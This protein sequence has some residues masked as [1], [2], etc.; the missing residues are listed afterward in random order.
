MKK[1]TSVLLA[2]LIILSSMYLILGY[3]GVIQSPFSTALAYP[4][5]NE[6]DISNYA[7]L[8]S[9]TGY[10][11]IISSLDELDVHA[12]GINGQT[13][14]EVVSWYEIKNMENGWI[15]FQR[16]DTWTYSSRYNCD[17]YTRVWNKILKGQV[18]IVLGG[19]GVKTITGYDVVALTSSA[20]LSTY[21]EYIT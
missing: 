9:D 17:I 7:P 16:E 12:Y 5:S 6:I 2:V 11:N 1:A 18:V 3:T 20:P 19:S 14:E 13:V 21:E 4:E 15:P 10:S 8:L